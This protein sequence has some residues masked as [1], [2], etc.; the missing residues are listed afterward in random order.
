MQEAKYEE[1]VVYFLFMLN[2]AESLLQNKRLKVV[3][4]I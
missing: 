3:L 4:V 1:N 2:S